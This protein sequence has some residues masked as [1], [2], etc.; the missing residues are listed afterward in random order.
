MPIR[1]VALETDTVQTLQD[2]G[3]DANGQQPETQISDGDGVPCRHCLAM[4]EEG[5]PY[6]VL[7][8]RPFPGPQPYA[9]VGPIFL[10]AQPCKQGGGTAAIPAVLY[11]PQYIIRGYDKNDRIVYGTGKVTDTADIP[12]AAEALFDNPRV[13]Y[14]HVRSASNNCYHC[15]IERG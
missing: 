6:L 10:H 14:V 5:A 11:S 7:A 13:A 12:Q 9:E 2:G 4:I 8:H 15:R 1:F 3:P